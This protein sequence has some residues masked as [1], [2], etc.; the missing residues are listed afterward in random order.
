MSVFKFKRP[1]TSMCVEY[2]RL[3]FVIMSLKHQLQP[4]VVAGGAAGI[5]I[6]RVG[7]EVG[8]QGTGVTEKSH[9]PEDGFQS[10]PCSGSRQKH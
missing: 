5:R 3:P 8:W 4:V 7:A 9:C 2:D 1:L 6:S 10:H